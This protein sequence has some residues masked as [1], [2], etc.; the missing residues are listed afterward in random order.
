MLIKIGGIE[1][2]IPDT[3]SIQEM[4]KLNNISGNSLMGLIVVVNGNVIRKEQWDM[5]LNLN[6]NIEIIRM[7]SGG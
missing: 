5:P 1:S 4:L 7:V 3:S 6:D 2:Q